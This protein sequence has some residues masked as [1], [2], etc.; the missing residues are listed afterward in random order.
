MNVFSRALR[1]LCV[2]ILKPTATADV[3]ANICLLSG[4]AD[5]QELNQVTAVVFV[6]SDQ[7]KSDTFLPFYRILFSNNS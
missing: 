6:S 2:L 1:S 5:E 4:P 3:L 7:R